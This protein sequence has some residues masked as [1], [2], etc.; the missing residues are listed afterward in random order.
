[1]LCCD[2][3]VLEYFVVDNAVHSTPPWDH[4][5]ML[6]IPRYSCGLSGELGEQFLLPP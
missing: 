3:E 4:H 5:N 2:E 1:M 6:H